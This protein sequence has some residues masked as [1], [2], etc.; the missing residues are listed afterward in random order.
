MIVIYTFFNNTLLCF[1]CVDCF[2]VTEWSSYG[3]VFAFSPNYRFCLAGLGGGVSGSGDTGGDIGLV[4][5]D[6][7]LLIFRLQIR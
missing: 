6:M 2:V 1:N 4:I 3:S 7:S 5:K